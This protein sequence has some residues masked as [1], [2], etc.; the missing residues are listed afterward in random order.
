MSSQ[1]KQDLL[2][3]AI[4][5]LNEQGIPWISNN[6]GIHIQITGPQKQRVDYWPTTGKWADRTSGKKGQRGLIEVLAHIETW[7][8]A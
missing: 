5:S 3:A 1:L 2:D 7:S 4:Q 8:E 6:G